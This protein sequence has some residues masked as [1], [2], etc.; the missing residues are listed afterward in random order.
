MARTSSKKVFI[1][2]G[3]MLVAG[4]GISAARSGAQPASKVLVGRVW[5]DHL[6]T[7]DTEHFEAFIALDD[8][9]MGAFQRTSSYEGSF[10]VFKYEPRGEGKLQ[11]LFPQSKSKH[12]VK[13]AASTCDK[14]GFDYCLSMSGAPRGAPEYV[15]KKGWEIEGKSLGEVEAAFEDWKQKNLPA[16]SD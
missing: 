8:P 2:L 10:E 7:R 15:S 16:S 11:M 9:S 3:A 5:V 1:A 12:D 14:S 4:L 13:Y 6:P